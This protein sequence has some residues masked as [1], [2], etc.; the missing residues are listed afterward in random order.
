[1]L[2]VGKKSLEWWKK[3]GVNTI[4]EGIRLIASS[5]SPSSAQIKRE[6]S[7]LWIIQRRKVREG[8]S[9]EA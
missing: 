2:E 8:M 7:R 5:S 1:M 9:F 4:G 3:E 6:S